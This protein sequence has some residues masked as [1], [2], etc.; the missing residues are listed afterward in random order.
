MT[1]G[2]I[3][4]FDEVVLPQVCI[5]KPNSNFLN[6]IF[7]FFLLRERERERE[8]LKERI[9]ERGNVYGCEEERERERES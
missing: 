2:T 3:N 4:I 7:N 1:V 9:F 8:R 5:R 6:R